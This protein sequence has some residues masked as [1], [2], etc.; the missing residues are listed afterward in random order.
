[1][2]QKRMQKNSKGIT[3]I[4]LVITIIVLLILAGISISMLTGQNGILTKANDSEVQQS[5]ASVKE[6]I[7][8]AYNEYQ[9]EIKT[10]DTNKEKVIEVD[11]IASTSVVQV[12][13]IEVTKDTTFF[14]YLL[15]KEY[16][17]EE[18]II[19][20]K[21]LVGTTSLG[22]GTDG[23]KDVYKIEEDRGKY[24]LN[25][26][27][28]RGISTDLWEET[29]NTKDMFEIGDFRGENQGVS[30]ITLFDDKRERVIF[31]K[32][33]IVLNNEKIDA[34]KYIEN[35]NGYSYLNSHNLY[36][37]MKELGKNFWV[38]CNFGMHEFI[39]EKDGKEYKGTTYVSW[40]VS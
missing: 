9:I 23:S 31:E 2:E 33:Y 10:A 36:Y 1:M 18:G 19:N 20:K 37:T 24:V 34:S 11:K 28:D 32:I 35:E 13:D 5:H 16:I 14:E 29:L 17:N 27:D 3:L 4:A 38:D 15:A 26:Y 30:Y 21:K 6:A 22:N 40:L 8:L 12:A 25:Y 39:I 7:T